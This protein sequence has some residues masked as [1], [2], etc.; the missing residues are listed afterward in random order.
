MNEWELYRI[1]LIKW[2]LQ[3]DI[4]GGDVPYR[5]IKEMGEV[6]W[7][8]QTDTDSRWIVSIAIA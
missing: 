5:M 1:S 2:E 3:S 6:R 7:N 4:V 8:I